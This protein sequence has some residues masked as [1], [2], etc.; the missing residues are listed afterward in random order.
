L[1][2]AG[3]QTAVCGKW[4]LKTTPQAAGFD[5]AVTFEGNGSWYGRPVNHH[6]EI[7]KPDE[8]VDRYCAS[9][10]IRFLRE[11]DRQKPFFLWHC[12]Q[13]PHMDHRHSWPASAENL[14][15][16]DARAMPL[17]ATWK[18]DA[19]DKPGWLAES[20]NRTQVLSYGYTEP[21]NLREHIRA[22]RA[23]L[24]D[25]DDALQPLWAEL[26]AQNLWENTVVVFMSDNGWMLGEH[27]LTS[28]VLAYEASA[29]V[30]L[31]IAAP[32]IRSGG[33][34]DRL[35]SN[36]DLAPTLLAF[37]GLG[38][39]PA[40]QG[41]SL[42]PLLANPRLQFRPGLRYEGVG[43]YG[44]V[45][46]LMAWITERWKVIHTLGDPPDREPRFIEC[47]DLQRDPGETRNVASLPEFSAALAA[48]RTALK[49]HDAGDS[50]HD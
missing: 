16:H 27:G 48:A 12:T 47:Y 37:A 15:R 38:V 18:G 23:T 39:P 22:Y 14:A 9:A 7:V 42:R 50:S 32:G 5:W 29:R 20:R 24:A 4:H 49:A 25:L 26:D 30:P 43:G 36:L 8:L 17:P 45:P 34:C 31:L 46:P 3:Y 11:R 19:P 1:R 28:K 6:G 35:V 21:A 2:A 41:R 13:L 33:Q 44:N 10:S 40:Y